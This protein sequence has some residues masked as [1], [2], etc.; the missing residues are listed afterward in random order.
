MKKIMTM[1]SAAFSFIF[2]IAVSADYTQAL[3]KTMIH[4]V[5]GG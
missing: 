4:G 3:I 5:G 2:L 1:C